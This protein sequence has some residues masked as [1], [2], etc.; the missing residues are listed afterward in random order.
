VQRA[1][2]GELWLADA[3]GGELA[4]LAFETGD[5]LEGV[6][7]VPR[8]ELRR[9]R[10]AVRDEV[11]QALRREHADRLAQRRA[12]DLE[13][14]GELALVELRAGRDQA[15]H[16]LL[17]QAGGGV[18][19]QHARRDRKDAGHEVGAVDRAALPILYAKLRRSARPS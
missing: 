1:D 13:L 8:R 7:D 4:G 15:F 12:R 14:F 9:D 16:D 19:V 10:T 3:G 5:D 2:L 11:H 17:A 6:G 18:L